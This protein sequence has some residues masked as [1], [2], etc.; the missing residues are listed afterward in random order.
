MKKLKTKPAVKRDSKALASVRKPVD[1]DTVRQNISNLIGARAVGMVETTIDEVEKG[2]YVA[3]KYL[4]E[5]IG[6][7][8]ASGDPVPAGENVLAKTL[9]RRLGL[10]EDVATEANVTKGIQSSTSEV[11]EKETD[12]VE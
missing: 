12:A 1:L 11:R 7:F 10:P 3:M 5:L 2:H 8:P 6:L 9:L 4:F